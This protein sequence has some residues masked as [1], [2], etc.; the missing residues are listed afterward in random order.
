MDDKNGFIGTSGWHYKHWRGNFYPAGVT[1]A[2]YLAHYLKT[3]RRWRSTTPSTGCPRRRRWPTGG[4]GAGRLRV[5]REGEPLH[6]AHEKAQGPAGQLRTLHGAGAGAGRKA[7]AGA[8]PVAARLAL[9]RGPVR[10]FP[11]SPALRSTATPSSS[12]TRAGT[13]TGPTNCS[14]STAAPS[15]STKSS[16]TSRRSK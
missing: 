14:G 6:H 8:F 13:T 4:L 16:T 11:G 12:A 3:L 10:G 5:C 7:G 2:G 15:A 9:R 1:P